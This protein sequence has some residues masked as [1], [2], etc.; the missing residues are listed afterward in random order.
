VLFLQ[1]SNN[2]L[3]A[4][5]FMQIIFIYYQPVFLTD[6]FQISAVEYCISKVYS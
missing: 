5:N 6:K 4:G 1:Y 3:L 2:L